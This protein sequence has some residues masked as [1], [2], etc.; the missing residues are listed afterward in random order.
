[1]PGGVVANGES[2]EEAF[3]RILLQTTG[4]KGIY[5]E[6]LYTF[7]KPD[8]DSRGH[9]VSVVYYALVDYLSL[10]SQIDISRIL[11]TPVN[12]ISTDTFAYDHAEIIAYA[13]KRLEWKLEYTNVAQNILHESFT[14]TALQSI[15]EVIFE[16]V[17]DKRNFRKKILALGLIQE[18]GDMDKTSSRRPARLYSF[19]D[20]ELKMLE[21]REMTM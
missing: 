2:L 19:V 11:T 21:K 18:T 8:R 7:G 20:T 1:M 12:K 10:A 6:Q 5:K 4:L 15:Y 16:R 9:V 13:K 14:L 17:L 3:D